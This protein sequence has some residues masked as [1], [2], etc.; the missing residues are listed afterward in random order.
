[1]TGGVTVVSS[2]P[3]MSLDLNLKSGPKIQAEPAQVRAS[4]PPRFSQW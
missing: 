1:M 4:P 2:E 3:M